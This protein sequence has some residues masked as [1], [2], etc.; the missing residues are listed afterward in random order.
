MR[1]EIRQ[2]LQSS[3]GDAYTLGREL[4]GGGMSRVFIARDEQLGREVVVKVLKPELA[5]GLSVER[6]TREI[7]LAAALQEPHIVPVHSAGTTGDGL[8][9]YTMPFVAG[10]SLRAR[11]QRGPVPVTESLAILHDI[12]SALAYAHERRIV[13]RDIKPENVLLSSGTAVVT[14]F[15]IAKALSLSTTRATTGALTVEGTSIG[16]PAYMAPEQAVGDPNA[17]ARAD[18]YAWGMVAYE[19]LAGRHPFADRTTPQQQIAAQIVETPVAI[20]EIRDGIPGP[21]GSL[22]AQCLAKDP[23]ARPDSGAKL[24]QLLDSMDTRP[25]NASRPRRGVSRVA[26]RHARSLVAVAVLCVV[27]SIAYVSI[28]KLNGPALFD[29]RRIAVIPCENLTNS[30]ELAQLGRVAA[31]Y[32]TQEIVALDSVTVVGGMT[33]VAILADTVSAER[34][35]LKRLAASAHAGTIITCSIARLGD[36]L[37]V[38]ARLVDARTG[39]VKRVLAPGTGPVANPLAAFVS[40]RERLLG[41]LVSGDLSKR[42]LVAGQP[43]KYSAYILYVEALEL[44]MRQEKYEEANAL[45]ARAIAIDSTFGAA[46]ALLSMGYY[47]RNLLDEGARV[48]A[49]LESRREQLSAYDKLSADWLTALYRNDLA[50]TIRATQAQVRRDS[51]HLMLYNVGLWSNLVLDGSTALPALKAADSAQSASGWQYQ[52][53][54]LSKA[55]HLTGNHKAELS[56][57]HGG[58]VRYPD[59]WN[60]L[61][62]ELRALACVRRPA[63]A[64]A[65]VDSVLRTTTHPQTPLNYSAAYLV[66]SSNWYSYYSDTATAQSIIRRVSAWQQSQAW[67]Q[68][69]RSAVATVLIYS[70]QFDEAVALLRTLRGFQGPAAPAILGGLIGIAAARR[71][72][73]ERAMQIADSLGQLNRKWDSGDAQIWRASILTALD[74]KDEAVASLRQAEQKAANKFEWRVYREFSALHGYPAF[75]ALVAAR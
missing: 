60:L 21:L 27:A 71:G 41:A 53:L 28:A 46:F 8:P 69:R 40:L 43:P 20:G 42:L 58:R 5:A 25:G 68:S 16:T 64:L 12:A 72:D 67:A 65:L 70:N 36:S 2:V 30:T 11:L 73:A 54:E 4:G 62:A 39:T 3:L 10:E 29:S 47:N 66:L 23:E 50:G 15:G 32:L 33:V 59:N 6:F 26:R 17:D 38:D 37:R 14:D 56:A 51:S 31:D 45:S 61:N 22:I 9:W 19:M 7:K 74:R 57:A 24:L 48:A 55:Y 1:N 35:P 34:D 49:L 44:F 63:A 52:P 75:E 13:H 18:V